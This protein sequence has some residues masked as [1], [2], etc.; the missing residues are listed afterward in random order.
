MNKLMLPQNQILLTGIHSLSEKL[1]IILDKLQG[2]EKALALTNLEQSIMWA[3][4]AIEKKD[5]SERDYHLSE[6]RGLT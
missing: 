2:R 4:K 6:D 5:S 3:E 1:E